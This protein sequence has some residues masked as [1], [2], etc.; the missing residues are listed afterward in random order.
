MKKPQR[1]PSLQAFYINDQI[2]KH[3]NEPLA[4]TDGMNMK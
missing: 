3:K 1:P 4:G 2:A